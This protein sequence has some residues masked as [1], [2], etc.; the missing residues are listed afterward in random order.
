[1][2]SIRVQSF[3]CGLKKNYFNLYNTL[4]L[5]LFFI[6]RCC[7]CAYLVLRFTCFLCF[8][9]YRNFLA[10]APFTRRRHSHCCHL[11]SCCAYL[12]EVHALPPPSHRAM[13]AGYR[14]GNMPGEVLLQWFS[15][16]VNQRTQQV[17]L[18]DT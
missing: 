7:V 17:I 12:R 14:S 4:L 6:V 13:S 10:D 11:L 3:M 18:R 15:C 2:H 5:L 1:M 8:F 16:C 9:F